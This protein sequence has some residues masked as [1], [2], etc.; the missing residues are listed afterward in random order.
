MWLTEPL[1]KREWP[2]PTKSILSLASPMALT[3]LLLYSRSLVSMLFLGRLGRLP[4][5][6]GALA[7]GF[8]NITGYS[9]LSGLA[10]GMEPICGQAFGARRP[11]LLGPVLHRAV[12]LLLAASLPIAALWASMRSLLLLYSRSLVSMLFLGRLG[13]LPLAG[14]ALAIGFANIT[15]YSVLSGLAMGMEPICGQAFGARRPALLGPVLHRAVLLLLAASLPIAALWASMRSLLLL[16]SRSL[17]SML[18][19]GR[20]GRLPLAGGALAIGFANITGYSVLSGL[21]MGM[22]P[23]CGQAFGARRPALLGP[24]L[25]RAVLLL[26]AASLPIAALWASMRSLLLLYSRSLVSMLFLGRLGR[27]PLA[28]GALAIGFANITGYS[29]LSGLAMGMEPICGQAF[30]ARRPALL[31]P[32]L[33][34]AVLLLLAASLPIAALWASM[35]SLLLLYSR[36]LVSMLFLGRLGRLPL[37]GGALAIGFAN[38]TGYS[39]LSGLAMGM[40]PI[41]GQ[42]FG[43][44]RPA[45]LG[46]V[47]HRAVLLLLAASL[48]I[49]A[50]WASMRSL[51]LLY[52]RSLVSMLFLGRL[53][54]LPLAGGALAIGFANI[55]GYSVLSGLA[56]GM[57]PICGQAFGARRPALLGP[58]LHRA[59]LLLLAAS[60]PIAALWASMR[61]LLLLYSRSLVSMLF[62]GRLGRLPLAG[63]ALAIGFA[64]ITG[65][66]VLSGLA[67]GMEPICGQA[68]GA[69]RPALLGPVLH[70][71]RTTTSPPRPRP[72]FSP[73]SRTSSSIITLPFTYCAAAAA[74]LHLPVNYVLV[75]VLRLGICGVALAS[76][77]TNLNLLFLLLVYIYSSGV[78]QHTGALNFTAECLG[79]WRSLLNLAIPSCIGVCLEW[80]WYEIMLGNCPQTA[81]CGVLRGSARPRTGANINMWSFY[82]VGMPVAAGLAFW[83]RLDFP[84]LWLGMLAAQGT[85]VGLM[86][87]VVRRTDWNLQAERA[88]RLTGGP[89][90]TDT[91]VVVVVVTNEF[92][93]KQAADGDNAEICDSFDSLKIDQL[94]ASS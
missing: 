77:C 31:G 28:G 37:A 63:G 40:E 65:Y 90:E 20:L 56:M 22:E 21:A 78:H 49:A 2:S 84:G 88:Q 46:P 85:C 35:R 27:L 10:M 67:M 24:V 8:A 50:L 69:R 41:C 23:I 19:L 82:G 11:A 13:R 39:V 29:V 62:L 34:R 15:G 75:S 32:V 86:L 5:A 30:G 73:P 47:L 16:Y 61:S 51:L 57:E 26:L 25:H 92:D 72:T 53:G 70:L 9:V 45:L 4:L 44:R 38:I 6:G 60:L 52:S 33:H 58:V 76:V 17:V 55:T 81:G 36:S 7:I 64:N 1:I 80:W 68:F 48:P 71:A 59:V 93:E 54:R 12:L 83:G 91:A 3:G 66:S 18:F 89:V 42:A 43:A 87:V 94:T 74:L 14:G 79:N